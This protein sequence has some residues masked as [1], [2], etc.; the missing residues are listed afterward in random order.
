MEKPRIKYFTHY[1]CMEPTKL[2][3]GSPAAD[4]KVDYVIEV[5][6]DIGYAVDVI[7]HA[8]ISINGGFFRGY[9]EERGINTLRYFACCGKSSNLL[10]KIF[11]RFFFNLG[12]IVWCL[13]NIKRGEQIIVYHSLCYDNIFIKLKK[14]L[15]FT[16]VGDVEEIYQDVHPTTRKKS[17][18]EYRFFDICDKFLFP[19]TILNEKL[20][21][22]NK[23]H[24]VIHGI[25]KVKDV[26]SKRSND[27][28]IHIL[29]SGTYDPVKG[30]ALASIEAAVYLSEQYHLHI[31]G[32]GTNEQE[33]V[34][35]NRVEELKSQIKCKITFH[36]YLNDNDFNNL[37]RFCSIGLCTQ[38]PTSKLNLTSFPSKILNYM[39][40]GLVVISG[41]NRAIEESLVGDLLYYY[42][43][44]DP[45]IMAEAI[46]S[47]K[48]TNSSKGILRL[49]LL[50]EELHSMLFD[51]LK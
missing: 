38:D 28:Y 30:G 27:G 5:L 6:N 45:L 34:L 24:L 2:R 29:Y 43:S 48:D 44:Q 39:S 11:N 42:D 25:Y 51:F 40:N 46:M 9:R 41:R 7:S 32:F 1:A 33:L 36:G 14:I 26:D 23:P 47:I 4:T 18:Q 50:D 21:K 10:N 19:N 37:L 16:L 49:N 22:Y 8:T 15:K 3:S 13:L 12:F 35:K 20:N 31:T 17:Q